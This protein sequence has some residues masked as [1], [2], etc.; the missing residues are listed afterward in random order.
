MAFKWKTI[1]AFEW[2]IKIAPLLD[3]IISH[4]SIADFDRRS[5][6]FLLNVHFSHDAHQSQLLYIAK[7]NGQNVIR[8]SVGL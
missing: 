3:V 7:I 2:N 6:L 4:I 1:G 8:M 5:S